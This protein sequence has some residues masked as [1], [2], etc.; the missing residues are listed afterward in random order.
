MLT[1]N[2]IEISKGIFDNASTY[3]NKNCTVIYVVINA[4][5]YGFIVLA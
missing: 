4:Q 2:S 5:P 3:I 1:E